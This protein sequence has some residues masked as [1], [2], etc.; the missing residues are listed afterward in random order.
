M[1]VRAIAA[2]VYGDYVQR[3]RLDELHALL[4]AARANGYATMTLSAFADRVAARAFLDPARDRLRSTS[5]PCAPTRASDSTCWPRTA[6][7]PTGPSAS[8][9]AR[10]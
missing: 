7:S 5:P 6:I 10:C 1:N 9:A 4:A 3:E 2:P 8:P